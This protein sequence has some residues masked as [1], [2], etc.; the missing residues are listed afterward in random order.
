MAR[1]KPPLVGIIAEDHSDVDSAHI[2]IK[3]IANNDH[4]G[5]RRS[6]GKGCGRINRKCNA[7]AR[8]LLQKGCSILVL[9][10]DLDT[11]DIQDL[12]RKLQLSL[13]PCPIPK[14]LICIPVQEFE[15]WLLSDPRAIQAG[16][17]LRKVPNVKGLPEQINSPKEYLGEIIHRASAGE[18][19]Y[20][21]TEHNEKIAHYLSLGIAL[22]RCTSFVP[23]YRFVQLHL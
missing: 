6:V 2:L 9:I 4:I 15:A 18:K 17:K 20:I 13:S 21:N 7:W 22:K 8:Q 23:F 19:I 11:N 1:R 12:T 16:M 5:V 3:R 10:H 14:Y